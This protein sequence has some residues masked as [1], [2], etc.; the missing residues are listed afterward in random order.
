MLIPDLI[1]EQIKTL[2]I[3]STSELCGVI[4]NGDVI[5]LNNSHPDPEN[6][7]TISANDLSKFNYSEIESIW[8]THHKDTQPGYFT[9]TDVELAH[10]S[11]KPI[12]LYHTSFDVWD[13]YEPNNPDPFPLEK[14]EHTPQELE[15]YLNTRFHWGRSDCFAIVRRYLLGVL[16]VDIGEFTRTQLDNFPPEDYDCPW[17]MDKFELLPLGTQPQLNDVFGIALKGGKKVNHAA[18]IVKPEENIIFHSPSTNSVSKL[19]QY[20][21][22]WR[23]RTI[24]HGRLK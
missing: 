9:Y 8:H 20:G 13:Y 22:Y 12:V 11:Q 7:F 16:G 5:A 6:H 14:K 23:R 4:V 3:N 21:D 19:E 10:Q 17:S 18:V 24:L 15:F 1:K 2:S